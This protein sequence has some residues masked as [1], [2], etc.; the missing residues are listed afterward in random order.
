MQ[1]MAP[2]LTDFAIY[3]PLPAPIG[4][5]GVLRPCPNG[6]TASGATHIVRGQW[7]P[8]IHTKWSYDS[9]RTVA[10]GRHRHKVRRCATLL[11]GL[12]WRP[13]A[14]IRNALLRSLIVA[15]ERS[16]LHGRTKVRIRTCLHRLAGGIGRQRATR[17][18]GWSCVSTLHNQEDHQPGSREEY[19]DSGNNQAYKKHLATIATAGSAGIIR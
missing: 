2:I 19:H 7:Q 11:H 16:R 6:H 9:S 8:T 4:C 14:S 15:I 5:V 17:R 13:I 10:I 3:I 18:A 12:Q 1:A